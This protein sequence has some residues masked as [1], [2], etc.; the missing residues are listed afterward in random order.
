M[1]YHRRIEEA[2]Q[3]LRRG[4]LLSAEELLREARRLH[5]RSRLRAP[6]VEKGLDPLLRLGRRLI[7]RRAEG[8]VL[9]HFPDRAAALEEEIQD[10]ALERVREA[11]DLALL[12]DGEVLPQHAMLFASFLRLHRHSEFFRL[13]VSVLWGVL[14]GYLLGHRRDRDGLEPELLPDPFF[15]PDPE[16]RWLAD[17]LEE[18]LGRWEERGSEAATAFL[19]WA[20]SM[21]GVSDGVERG[22]WLW[23]AARLALL[24]PGDGPRALALCRR[25]AGAE[26]PPAAAAANLRQLAALECNEHLLAAPGVDAFSRIEE[27][28]EEARRLGQA[29]P[30]PE[31]GELLHRRRPAADRPSVLSLSW[32][33]GGREFLLL[34]LHRGAPVDALLFRLREAEDAEAFAITPTRCRE[35][36]QRWLR[37]ADVILSPTA[38]PPSIEAILAGTHRLD[39]HELGTAL[40]RVRPSDAPQP[41]PP[42]HPLFRD[43]PHP[44][45]WPA[46]YRQAR[47][48]LP[49]ALARVDTP[50]LR[51]EWG[52]ANLRGFGHHGLPRCAALAQLTQILFPDAAAEGVE[53]QEVPFSLPLRW[54][55]LAHRPWPAEGPRVEP[56]AQVPAEDLLLAERPTI[57]QLASTALSV[58]RSDVLVEDPERADRLAAC[59]ARSIDP[60]RVTV[61]RPQARC[62]E[63]ELRVLELWLGEALADGERE[64]DVLWLYRALALSPEGC[65]EAWLDGSERPRA[66]RELRQRR[67]ETAAPSCRLENTAEGCWSSQLARRRE[68][69]RVWISRIEDGVDASDLPV[70]VDDL[71]E[72]VRDGDDEAAIERLDHLARRLASASL[73]VLFAD[74]G[75]LPDLLPSVLEEALPASRRPRSRVGAASDGLELQVVPPG[76]EPGASLV[77]EEARTLLQRRLVLW[78][79]QFG[80][81]AH[82]VPRAAGNEEGPARVEGRAEVPAHDVVLV[83]MLASSSSR[84]ALLLLLRLTLASTHARA[85]VVCLDP[86]LGAAFPELL[87][88]S[89]RVGGENAPPRALDTAA[90]IF[91][92]RGGSMPRTWAEPVTTERLARFWDDSVGRSEASTEA[93]HSKAERPAALARA[94]R[95]WRSTPRLV[96]AGAEDRGRAAVARV[97]LEL[98]RQ[99]RDGGALSIR[100]VVWAGEGPW[101]LA[102]AADV[103]ALE[104]DEP[105]VEVD[106][107][108]GRRGIQLRPGALAHPP[109]RRWLAETPG[110][111]LCVS[112]AES[113][114]PR[115]TFARGLDAPEL[116][117]GSRLLAFVDPVADGTAEALAR[118][119][120]AAAVAVEAGDAPVWRWRRQRA[121]DPEMSCGRCAATS[122]VA[123]P[124]AL[125]PACG[126]QLLSAHEVEG[127]ARR[128]R[129]AALRENLAQAAEGRRLV[130]TVEAAQREELRHQLGL[131]ILDGEATPLFQG[132]PARSAFSHEIRTAPELLD[133]PP[134]PAHILLDRVPRDPRWLREV[135]ARLACLGWPGAMVEVLDHPL[136]WYD[137]LPLRLS[138]V[139]DPFDELAGRELRWE[140]G[141]AE[142]EFRYGRTLSA[143]RHRLARH[144]EGLSHGLLASDLDATGP[145]AQAALVAALREAAADAE[146]PDELFPRAQTWIREALDAARGQGLEFDGE[147]V[148][149]LLLSDL[150]PVPGRARRHALLLTWARRER[151]LSSRSAGVEVTVERAGGGLP[152]A[153]RRS[154]FGETVELEPDRLQEPRPSEGPTT[155][156]EDHLAPG[157]WMGVAGSGRTEALL[158]TAQARAARGDRV[159]VVVPEPTSLL[160]FEG[161]RAR[162]AEVDVVSAQEL[163]VA[164]LAEL[165]GEEGAAVPPRPLPPPG[166]A[167]GEEIRQELLREVS[168]LYARRCGGV[169]PLE[170]R[171]LRRL[172]EE[173]SAVARMAAAGDSTVDFE[174]LRECIADARRRRG[175]LEERDLFEVARDRV[176]RHADLT[177]AWRRRWDVL[178]LDD[179][180]AFAEASLD[181]MDRLFAEVS[182]W[183]FADPHL[184]ESDEGFAVLSEGR[185]SRTVPRAVAA[186]VDVAQ[187][188]RPVTGW[189]LRT[190]HRGER[191]AQRVERVLNLPTCVRAIDVAVRE[192]GARR[193]R[194]GVVLGHE[195]D[196][197]QMALLL[198]EEGHRVWDAAAV[199]RIAVGGPRE[200][201]ALCLLLFD[202]ARLQPSQGASLL[203]L[204]LGQAR[205]DFRKVLDADT[206]LTHVGDEDPRD[207]RESYVFALE[208]LTE[209]LEVDQPLRE[210]ARR[211]VEA[212]VLEGCHRRASSRARLEEYLRT[213]GHL[214]WAQLR[215]SVDPSA[216]AAVEADR[217]AIWVL[218]PRDLPGLRFAHLFHVC[219]GYEPAHRH[220]QVASR[221]DERLTTL[222]SEHDP[223][224]D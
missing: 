219:S 151:L 220:I 158:R 130:L 120:D 73:Y 164:V 187:R 154:P 22:R 113:L 189:P 148:T 80:P 48:L 168:R 16:R 98:A 2:Q 117:E 125:C 5:G 30:P 10:L 217:E 131:A 183:D 198:R 215:S 210:V 4:D 21:E 137:E 145:G 84:S 165:G 107:L 86:R 206:D 195:G 213:Q 179:R 202:A 61:E 207:L 204:L 199:A 15:L 20:E 106:D 65:V 90:Q 67:R 25:A 152:D 50:P 222:Y 26:L 85:R 159:L 53:L 91:G 178:L 138:T 71:T 111:G 7:G 103:I 12:E 108:R 134:T 139:I 94:L 150:D 182:R 45:P 89:V 161:E 110:L 157:R 221:V 24:G 223:F 36:L 203:A 114:L 211:A 57:E 136:Q 184:S 173:E 209:F 44:E 142:V 208:S 60:R 197:R 177:D 92:A 49:E 72:A 200:L 17:W 62:P 18:W 56:A 109:L 126:T 19:A 83:P 147:R 100:G 214:S 172:I 6:V 112:P 169:P 156:A 55:S 201:L 118:R 87:R 82:W 68:R 66:R 170:G 128:Q 218:R 105:E 43:Q 69:G 59:V 47:Q 175:W 102:E 76:Y 11:G 32:S 186:A 115:G 224:Q 31:L 95:G 52:H 193:G 212:G 160:R 35:S 141:R 37:P 93:A 143:L 181:L 75:L 79:E 123:H 81:A 146:I 29:W 34:R 38:P 153:L 13:D 140:A 124:M 51:S 162:L 174:L 149:H 196:R 119:L 163:A 23:I 3:C 54:P 46:L 135:L 97:L 127:A 39:L 185:T 40:P 155:P 167:A 190:R 41:A 180:H 64:L 63:L 144:R 77:A 132:G 99:T 70:V 216:V 122:P 42:I 58:E 96:V 28:G 171:L 194:V 166:S 78:E 133:P 176:A 74:G 101:P 205:W 27:L 191:G 1:A 104:G 129:W 188:N 88:R 192:T 14:R 121:R 8:H 9:P 33:E 116:S